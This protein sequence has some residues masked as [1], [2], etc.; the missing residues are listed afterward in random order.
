P[1][2]YP[3]GSAARARGIGP[4]REPIDVGLV[5]DHNVVGLDDLPA[6]DDG[7]SGYEESYA[8]GSPSAVEP[9]QGVGRPAPPIRQLLAHADLRNAVRQDRAARQA[10]RAGQLDLVRARLLDAQFWTPNQ[11]ND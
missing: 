5:I 3:G 8:A 9:H 1:D 4:L 6:I 7:V 10:E 2:L 11:S